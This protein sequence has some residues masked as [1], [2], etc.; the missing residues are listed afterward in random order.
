MEDGRDRDG[1]DE[2]DS[3]PNPDLVTV[4]WPDDDGESIVRNAAELE[5]WLRER[6]GDA[7]R[8]VLVY[9]GA[10]NEFVYSAATVAN[11]YTAEEFE[12]LA[13][14]TAFRDALTNPHYESLF[15]L[16]ETEAAVTVF[17]D[18]TL[19]QVP[20]GDGRGFV[21]TVERG[22]GVAVNVGDLVTAVRGERR[23]R[24]VAEE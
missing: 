9:E 16:G 19:V 21:L 6:Y 2:S 24:F 4:R 17:A 8:T 14:E 22:H 5:G 11:R 10:V 3:L 13:E 7:L 15:H 12:R 1:K 23:P 18:A 20:L